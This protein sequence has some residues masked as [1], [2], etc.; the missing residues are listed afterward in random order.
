MKLKLITLSVLLPVAGFAQSRLE[1]TTIGK[2]IDTYYSSSQLLGARA[3]ANHLADTCESA[4]KNENHFMGRISYHIEGALKTA[5]EEVGY[6]ASAYYLPSSRTAINLASQPLCTHTA[7]SLQHTLRYSNNVPATAV[8]SKLN[9]FASTHNSL[10]QKVL[11]GDATAKLSF[12]RHWQKFMGCLAYVESLSDPDTSRSRSIASTYAPSNYSK[13]AGVKFY[14]DS[15]ND[16]ESRLNIGLYQFTPNSSGNIRACLLKWNKKYP[17]C[18]VST[19]SS[20][21]T[22][23]HVLGSRHQNFNAFCGVDKILQSF[24][25]QVNTTDTARTHPSNRA[26]SGGLKSA[27]N[28][29]VTPHFHSTRA[30]NHFG[31]LQNSTGEN[32]SRLMTCISKP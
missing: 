25:I 1:F 9:A 7:T 8:I 22:L 16:P 13:P 24:Y 2:K 17:N 26:S 27:A 11:Q 23:V 10:R 5:H 12:V 21:N 32:L 20:K 15:T 4:L 28:R 18:S 19:S 3:T 6:V 31:P 29:C 30:Y 14:Y